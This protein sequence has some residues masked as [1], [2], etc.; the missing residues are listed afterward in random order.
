MQ[1]MRWFVIPPKYLWN[2]CVA[3]HKT[4]RDSYGCW[5]QL[6]RRPYTISRR[7]RQPDAPLSGL[8]ARLTFNPANNVGQDGAAV[9][10]SSVRTAD[11]SS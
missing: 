4:E 6:Q 7:G 2:N 11:Y 1:R 5:R 10:S 8:H 9:C 3:E